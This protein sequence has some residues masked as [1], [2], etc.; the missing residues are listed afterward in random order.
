MIWLHFPRLVKDAKY[1][2]GKLQPVLPGK[3]FAAFDRAFQTVSRPELV[4]NFKSRA[5]ARGS[6]LKRL[7]AWCGLGRQVK[8]DV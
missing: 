5:T 7:N 6:W 4:H 2:Y 1:L 8:R 3:D